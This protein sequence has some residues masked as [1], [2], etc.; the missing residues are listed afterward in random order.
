MAG[1]SGRDDAYD[2]RIAILTQ[3]KQFFGLKSDLPEDLDGIP[4]LSNR[5]SWFFPY[6][7]IRSSSDIARL[8]RVFHQ[9]LAENPLENK[10][11]WRA[12]DEALE[13]KQ[14]NVNLTMALYWIRPKIFLNLDQTNRKY[15][16]VRLPADG[17]NAK[18]YTEAVKT[19]DADGTSFPEISLAAW[20]IQN[21]RTRKTAEEKEAE[22]RAWG[23]INYWFASAHWDEKNPPDQT[24][25]FLDEGIWENEY[26]NRYINEVLSM[27][28]NDKIAIRSVSTQR[29]DLPFDARNKT[30]ARMTI[31]AIGTVVAN[32]EDG[33]TVEVDISGFPPAS[34]VWEMT[35]TEDKLAEYPI[36]NGRVR[37]TFRP[38]Q[39][40]TLLV[41]E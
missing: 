12:F 11:F 15:L 29:K 5:K 14:T 9:A 20:G 18:F 27:R 35:V 37:L 19:F 7:P 38:W 16:G 2:Q 39:V 4:I 1:R 24:E 34:H 31:K 28:V 8:W 26:N 21:E 36:L 40:R 23:G 22:Y 13:V 25:R 10:E 30:V 33:K 17:L 41:V 3:V 6:Q 32:R